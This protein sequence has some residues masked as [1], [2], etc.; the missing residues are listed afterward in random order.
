MKGVLTWVKGHIVIVVMLLVMLALLP[1]AYIMSMK[2]N[3]GIQKRQ[4]QAYN[5]EKQK[6]ERAKKVTY[7]LPR[8]STTESEAELSET[9]APNEQV[10][11]WYAEQRELRLAQVA[12][13]TQAAMQM[14]RGEHQALVPEFPPPAGAGDNAQKRSALELGRALV[15]ERGYDRSAYEILIERMGG[16]QPP[17]KE[18]VARVVGEFR[19]RELDKAASGGGRQGADAQKALEQQLVERRLA[20]YR[21]RADNISFYASL[22]ALGGGERSSGGRMSGGRGGYSSTSGATLIPA[23]MQTPPSLSEAY[24]YQWNYWVVE[25]LLRAI[26]KANSDPT[27]DP[28]PVPLSVVKRVESISLVPFEMPKAASDETA[29]DDMGF[30]GGGPTMLRGATSDTG[31]G[32]SKPTITGRKSGDGPYD[33]RQATMTVVV[34]S[35]RLP[36]LLSAIRTTNLMTVTDLDIEDVDVWSDLRQGYFYGDENVVRATIGVESVWLRDWTKEFMPE[37]VR[38]ALGIAADAA[39]GVGGGAESDG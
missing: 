37:S 16:G 7:A 23:D 22:E 2:M 14:N 5:D 24:V 6:I 12:E 9:R 3:A 35:A 36:A 13:V 30:G 29:M 26:V 34:S 32:T 10:S 19:D 8:I 38:T 21:R 27:G 15:G 31:G 17:A 11:N 39:G 33:V 4:S 28:L 25:D 1:T 18:E 20:E